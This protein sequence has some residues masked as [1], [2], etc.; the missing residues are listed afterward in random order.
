[1]IYNNHLIFY[2]LDVITFSELILI[3]K[4]VNSH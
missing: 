1:M 3:E 4:E 2:F